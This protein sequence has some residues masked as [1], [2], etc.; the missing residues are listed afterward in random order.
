MNT[1]GI[2]P[3]VDE[4]TAGRHLHRPVTVGTRRAADAMIAG[5]HRDLAL[6]VDARTAEVVTAVIVASHPSWV[7]SSAQRLGPEDATS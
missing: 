5:P 7:V 6:A 4:M 2:L 3:A 1:S